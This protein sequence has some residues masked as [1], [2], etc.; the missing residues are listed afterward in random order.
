MRRIAAIVLLAGMVFLAA[1]DTGPG[2][3][4]RL[5]TERF[6][7]ASQGRARLDVTHFW[8]EETDSGLRYSAYVGYVELVT[9]E[10]LPCGRIHTVSLTGLPDAYYR[11]FFAASLSL[12]AA[13]AEI[14]GDTAERVLQEIAVGT[15]PILGIQNVEREGFRLSYAAN[16][17]GR[18]FRLSCLRHLP[19]E[20]ELPT[21]RERIT[22]DVEGTHGLAQPESF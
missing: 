1:C 5:F 4:L 18:Y 21:L 8:V 14:E 15:L 10:A 22:N 3:D 17:A 9:A 2:M 11:E 7:R 6:N 12:L 19:P 20:V 13:F 16:E